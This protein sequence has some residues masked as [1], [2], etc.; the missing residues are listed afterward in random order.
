MFVLCVF[1]L[2]KKICGKHFKVFHKFVDPANEFDKPFSLDV[3]VYVYFNIKIYVYICILCLYQFAI[4]SVLSI[5][6]YL[7]LLLFCLRVYFLSLNA[8]LWLL[9]LFL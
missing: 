4:I 2:L 3:Q 1:S 8:L 6:F 5:M 7:L 9:L